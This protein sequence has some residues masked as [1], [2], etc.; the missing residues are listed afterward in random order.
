MAMQVDSIKTRVESA[1]G[2][3]NQHV[4]LEYHRQLSK[5]AFD[6]NLRLQ[7]LVWWCN[8]K[9]IEL[10]LKALGILLLELRYHELLSAYAFNCNLRHYTKATI[11]LR[12]SHR[13]TNL[14]TASS[15]Q[16]KPPPTL[17]G[18]GDSVRRRWLGRAVQVD[19]NLTS[20]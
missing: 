3:C 6:F 4:K 1:Y 11:Y 15:R 5:F 20:A 13:S 17:Y 12:S 7:R 14:S 18:I 16:C 2:V 10:L 19:P 9:R 8:M